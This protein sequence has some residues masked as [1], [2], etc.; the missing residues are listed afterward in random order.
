MQLTQCLHRQIF[1][2]T[3]CGIIWYPGKNGV[4]L[5]LPGCPC[6]EVSSK[7]RQFCHWNINFHLLHYPVYVWSRS[8]PFRWK[9]WLEAIYSHLWI[10]YFLGPFLLCCF[11]GKLKSLVTVL[12]QAIASPASSLSGE[13]QTGHPEQAENQ[14]WAEL[15]KDLFKET[16][17]ASVLSSICT[18]LI[19]VHH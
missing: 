15:A 12:C 16:C 4:N 2:Y 10:V 1:Q 14:S 13:L 8:N 5:V 19:A 6:Y 18:L 7:K 11:W 3:F 17:L 9:L